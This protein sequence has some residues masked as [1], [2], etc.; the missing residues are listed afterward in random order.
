MGGEKLP[1]LINSLTCRQRNY[2]N[3]GDKWRSHSELLELL[4][5]RGGVTASEFVRM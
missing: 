1:M 4:I 2:G 5:A 3:V